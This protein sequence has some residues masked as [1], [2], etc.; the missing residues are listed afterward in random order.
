MKRIVVCALS[1]MACVALLGAGA[2]NQRLHDSLLRL[3]VLQQSLRLH[4]ERLR[5]GLEPGREARVREKLSESLSAL[6][7]RALALREAELKR[8]LSAP[9]VQFGRI[10]ANSDLPTAAAVLMAAIDYIIMLAMKSQ[11]DEAQ[12][13]KDALAGLGA[14]HYLDELADQL[15]KL[16]CWTALLLG[17]PCSH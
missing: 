14:L 10:P 4:L 17:E 7:A 3:Q 6:R 1:F 8:G 2:Q 9:P 12:N 15:D 13:D 16:D 11:N 5:V